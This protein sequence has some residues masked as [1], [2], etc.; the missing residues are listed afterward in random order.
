MKLITSIVFVLLTST[1]YSFYNP[2]VGRWVT[3][4]PKYEEAGPNLYCFNKNVPVRYFDPLGQDIYLYTGNNSGNVLNDKCHQTIAVDL[5]STN[6]PPVKTG[7]TGFSFG[8]SGDWAWNWG[9]GTW[10]GYNSITLP[11]FLMVGEI[12]EVDAVVGKMVARK[13]TTVEEDRVWLEKMKRR[14]GESDVY[15]VGRHN[16]RAFSQR[17]FQKAPGKVVK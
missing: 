1:A 17:E 5:W 11:G 16:C 15:S 4:D 2:K 10:L 3:R 7:I 8:Y 12:Y 13:K 14:V 6:C 9:S